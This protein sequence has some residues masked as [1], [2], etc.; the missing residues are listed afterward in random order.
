[1]RNA[2]SSLLVQFLEALVH[3]P[4]CGALCVQVLE[5]LVRRR[6]RVMV[7]CNTINSCRAVDHFLSENDL[8]TANYHGDIPPRE[9]CVHPPP[10]GPWRDMP[11]ESEYTPLPCCTSREW[12]LLS[13]PVVAFWNAARRNP[14]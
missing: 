11:Y 4:S 10:A 7:F 6:Q 1:M 5:P 13:L 14:G 8:V 3:I 12:R 2:S 9:R